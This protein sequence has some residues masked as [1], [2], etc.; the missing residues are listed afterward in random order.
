[1]TVTTTA[2]RVVRAVTATTTKT[3]FHAAR[4]VSGFGPA[5]IRAAVYATVDRRHHY[6]LDDMTEGDL[7]VFVQQDPKQQAFIMRR[8]AWAAATN[9]KIGKY[10]RSSG[11]AR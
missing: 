4:W 1:M 8:R 9:R 2:R 3:A 5:L 10:P 7:K 11:R 6:L